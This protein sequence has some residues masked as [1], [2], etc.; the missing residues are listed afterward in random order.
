MR[1]GNGDFVLLDAGFAFDVQGESL[2]VAVGT[3]KYFSPEQFQ[4]NDRRTLLDFRSDLL[5]LGVTMYEMGA[6]RHPFGLQ[7][8]RP[9]QTSDASCAA[10]SLS[11]HRESI[12]VR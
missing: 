8:T 1:R 9:C 10:R 11:Q 12:T 6:G 3:P 7:A 5:P 2:S 4:F